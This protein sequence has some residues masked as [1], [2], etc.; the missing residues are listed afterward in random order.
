MQFSN[1]CRQG[2]Y[3]LP[4]VNGYVVVLSTIMPL[5]NSVMY[6][7]DAVLNFDWLSQVVFGQILAGQS[8]VVTCVDML[9]LRDKYLI[10]IVP[11]L[12]TTQ[13]DIYE[14]VCEVTQPILCN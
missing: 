11:L 13:Y 7:C 2:E 10:Y 9:P 14:H 3:H 6:F 1:P 4:L 12:Y 5:A 8:V